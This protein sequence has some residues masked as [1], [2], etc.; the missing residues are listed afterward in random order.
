[1]LEVYEGACVSAIQYRPGA[2]VLL[3]D[4]AG[5]LLILR[6]PLEDGRTLWF[7]PGGGVEGDESYEDCARRE[8]WEETGFRVELGPW[9][10]DRDV[11]M[12]DAGE[13]FQHRAVRFVERYYLTRL[14]ATFEPR[15]QSI[16]ER[17]DFLRGPDWYRW[18]SVVALS[19]LDPQSDPLVPRD[20][21]RLLAP[22]VAGEVRA[23]PVK[24]GL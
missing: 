20:L 19:A 17:E 4:P 16:G 3:L 24:V 5:R 21:P 8:V 14:D 6:A 15:P 18:M 1:M 7:P 9:V 12:D 10:W 2:R 13:M 11:T 22:L 23:V